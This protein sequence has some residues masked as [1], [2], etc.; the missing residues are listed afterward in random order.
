MSLIVKRRVF[1]EGF[2]TVMLC[3]LFC[4][5]PSLAGGQRQAVA[6][7]WFV[8]A[9]QSVS[10]QE[11]LGFAGSAIPDETTREDSRSP[12][13]IYIIAGLVALGTLTSALLKAY[14]DWRYGAIIISRDR[15][16]QLKLVSVPGLDNGTIIIDQGNGVK[17][18]FKEKDQPQAKEVME[19]L[20]SLIQK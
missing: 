9:E 16:G 11:S 4:V 5:T 17:V 6:I 3:R 12:A 14:K 10:I 18:I 19:S 2:T 15:G 20:M 8:P 1:I 7:T 13:A